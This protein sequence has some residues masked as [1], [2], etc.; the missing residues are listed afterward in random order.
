MDYEIDILPIAKPRMT[1]RDRW[2]KREP[3]LR[4]QAYAQELKLK[5]ARINL[6]PHCLSLTFILPMASSWSNGKKVLMEGLPHLQKPDLSNLVKA[7][8]DALWQNDSGIYK[9][10]NV[11]KYWGYKGK[12]IIRN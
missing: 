1:Q 8:E 7:Y 12:I 9:Y 5:T 11:A 3:V 2:A 10:I 4:Y 6:D